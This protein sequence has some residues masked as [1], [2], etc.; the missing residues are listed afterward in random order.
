VS[1]AASEGR[2]GDLRPTVGP[3]PSRFLEALPRLQAY[4]VVIV[5]ASLALP[6]WLRHV[7][8]QETRN[9]LVW[10]FAVVLALTAGNVELGR[11]MEGAVHDSPR[12]HRGLSACVLTAGM[13]L[14]PPYLLGVVA[15]GF[16]HARWRGLR[17]PLWRWVSLA[18]FMVLAGLAA[19]AVRR[20]LTG[21]QPN[22]MHGNG[23][24]GLLAVVLA[25]LAFLAVES[26][27]LYAGGVLN[28][29]EDARM[30]K[31]L[32]RPAFHL[33]EAAVLLMGG[34][35]AAVWDAG[36]WFMLLLVPVYA[37]AQRSVL[38]DELRQRVDT[39]EKT[40]LLRFETWREMATAEQ[41]RCLERG[42]AWSVVFADLDHFKRYNDTFG[43][44][45]GDAALAATALELRS[46]LRSRDL[47]ARFGGEEFCVLL[48]DTPAAKALEVGERLR[49]AI[50]DCE[51][52]DTGGRC[53][54]SI[55]VVAVEPGDDVPFV[56]VL[57][58]ADR[59]LFRAKTEGR[60]RVC[61]QEFGRA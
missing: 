21:H 11:W 59:A 60:N 24:R 19:A 13:L 7:G 20:L 41:Q 26:A 3:G 46:Q 10:T 54:I 8:V 32:R 34:L 40:G 23:G 16:G 4:L 14:P 48:P 37:L 50:E 44:L 58:A 15:L 33:H 9:P 25:A 61:V 47:V 52:P 51:L 27:L 31:T 6:V 43:H 29:V 2:P 28:G 17:V 1:G 38:N 18:S 35:S 56:D 55:G 49:G 57:S 22:L 45:A 42:S 12:P 36:A 39:D 53:S 5:L 30:R